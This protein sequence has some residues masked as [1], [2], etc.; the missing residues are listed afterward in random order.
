MDVHGTTPCIPIGF[1]VRAM[2]H[3][4][5]APD[6][7]V[8]PL[9][10]NNEWTSEWITLEA[11]VARGAA[12]MVDLREGVVAW[13]A[14]P[15]DDEVG[16]PAWVA[17]IKRVAHEILGS[18]VLVESGRPGHHHAYVVGPPGWSSADLKARFLAEADIPVAQQRADRP[19]RPPL[20][21]HRCGGAGALVDPLDF[22][23]ALAALTGRPGL[24]PLT[25]DSRR[26][27]RHG[28]PR[29]RF[30]RGGSPSRTSMAQSLAM[31]YVNA[32]IDVT[33]FTR[34]MLESGNKGGG[35]A[36]ELA[37]TRG[38]EEARDRCHQ[39]YEEA[40]VRVRDNPAWGHG[41]R[42]RRA[43]VELLHRTVLDHPWPPGKAGTTDRLVFEYLVAVAD[44]IENPV[45]QHS[46]RSIADGIGR[47]RKSV[48]TS[49]QR[50]H[51]TGLLTT[52]SRGSRS[53]ARTYKLHPQVHRN[54]P[55]THLLPPTPRGTW[56]DWVHSGLAG[57]VHDLFRG[58]L[59][60][61]AMRTLR[62]MPTGAVLSVA[63]L[64]DL[65]PGV[66]RTSIRRHLAAL[67]SAGLG[68]LTGEVGRGR[69]ITG[70]ERGV[71]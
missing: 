58:G 60:S 65:L 2:A 67:R 64:Q 31:R 33:A 30:T 68:V 42:E 11:A 21:P 36:Q 28:D 17:S 27:L 6:T 5:M 40:R 4:V 43:D 22:S 7:R 35:K 41:R 48:M 26:I 66:G 56:S 10:R 54:G 61:P 69:V 18:F 25:D 70:S 51:D 38:L 39:W 16:V 52:V 34:N 15:V 47:E 45:V 53:K 12:F 1:D 50:L 9:D 20:S 14:D 44:R 32:D 13:D 63:E 23:Q 24:I 71:L 8:R 57:P 46:V 59:P 49:L 3:A 37:R 62:A 55:D 29:G 19:I